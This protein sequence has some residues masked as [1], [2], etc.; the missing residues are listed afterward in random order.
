MFAIVEACGR[1]YKVEPGRFVDIDLTGA[2]E[3]TDHKFDKVLMIV[4]GADSTIG[5][6]YVEGALVTGKVVSEM[7]T[8]EV[9]GREVSTVRDKK[10]IVYKMKP[11]KGTRVK[12]GHRQQ[13]TRVMIDSIAIKDKVV[14]KSEK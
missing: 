4:D 14:A 11:K 10:V 5:K 8:N 3:G 6:P 2:E 12:R 13:F 1:Q 9:T 7:F